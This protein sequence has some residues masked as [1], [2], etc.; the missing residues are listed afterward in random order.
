MLPLEERADED[1][2][3]ATAEGEEDAFL[4]IYRRYR[5]RVY[6]YAYRMTGSADA[7]SD[8]THDC[9]ASLLQSPTRYEAQRAGLGTYLCSAA[10]HQSLRLA[11]GG[12]RERPS[13]D[14]AELRESQEPNP[15]ERLLEGE[16]SQLVRGAIAAL[17]PLDREVLIL[18]EYEE[19]EQAEIA[20]IVGAEPGTVRVRLHRARKRLRAALA[21]R[22]DSGALKV[23]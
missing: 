6:R 10:R 21:E 18:A 11:S 3:R 9:F 2:L 1:L 23:G 8:V 22:V 14:S 17:A 19:L 15:L 4:Q 12:R 5:D 16:R 7:A 20:R 13:G